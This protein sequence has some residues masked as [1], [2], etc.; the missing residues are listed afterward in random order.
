MKTTWNRSDLRRTKHAALTAAVL[1]VVNL[2]AINVLAQGA[3]N[4]DLGLAVLAAPNP[5]A[6]GKLLSY[7]ITVG[8]TGKGAAANVNLEMA[9][10]SGTSIYSAVGPRDWAIILPPLGTTGPVR[11]T[12]ASLA[13]GRPET[14]L[15]TFRV[16]ESVPVGQMVDA[17]IQITSTSPDPLPANNVAN[18]ST[19]VDARPPPHADLALNIDA[20]QEPVT[21]GNLMIIMF[22]IDNLGPMAATDVSLRTTTP[23]GTTF[24]ALTSSQGDAS[25]PEVGASGDIL[26]TLD[27]IPVHKPAFVTLV[28]QVV[29]GAGQNLL[30]VGE[31]SGSS[32][33]SNPQN[34]VTRSTTHVAPSGLPSD[35]SVSFDGSQTAVLSGTVVP[36]TVRVTNNG[37]TDIPSATVLVPVPRFTRF[38]GVTTSQGTEPRTPPIGRPGAVG[39]RPG[40]IP[41]GG[42]ATITISL[43]IAARAGTRLFGSALV[44]SGAD[45]TNLANNLAGVS[46][47]V[48]S[49]GDATIQWD[50]PD[51]TSGDPAP[52]NVKVSPSSES[53][54]AKAPESPASATRN[55]S[56]DVLC[57]NVYSSN[58]EP[59]VTSPE[60][61]YTTVPPNQTV[62]T[63]S[64]APGGSFFTV[65]A[66]YEDGESGAANS[67]GTGSGAG[68]TIDTFKISSTKVTGTGSGF[69][70]SVE[71]LFD[72]IPFVEPA[73]VK[74]SNTKAVQKG[75]LVISQTVDQYTS[76]GGSFL[77]IFRNADGGLT[78]VTYNKE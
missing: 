42:S 64:V 68:P 74:K 35:L 61:L 78:T 6:P 14:F 75:S 69:T 5:V 72:G 37:P 49:L 24:V 73:K 29:A 57:Y 50:P 27:V 60:N 66:S 53:S 2:F 1:V 26:C 28:T 22:F 33:D 46:A 4:I 76:G 62:V 13:P 12:I 34:N 44:T 54:I 77:I 32:V 40:L 70:D 45:D 15:F 7:R 63:G 17:S 18:V 41:S 19:L 25:T 16:A 9:T 55:G 30:A 20:L 36:M 71:V 52:L 65:T 67:D 10:P 11:A 59:V 58:S 21:S 3:R 48:Q 23:P 31:V 8:R 56:G 38:L 43:G 39:W 47:R 51:P